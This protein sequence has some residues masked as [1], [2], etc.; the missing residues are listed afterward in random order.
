MFRKTLIGTALGAFLLAG[1]VVPLQARDR[2]DRC[3]QRIRKAEANL[4]KEVRRHG[5][6][7]RQAEQRRRE[8]EQARA[9]CR[10]DEHHDRDHDRDHDR[11]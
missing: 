6:H 8:L 9:R 1:A 5:E 11:H 7:S 3:E 2:D 10:A 4:N